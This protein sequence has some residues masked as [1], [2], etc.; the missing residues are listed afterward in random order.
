[1]DSGERGLALRARGAFV[2]RSNTKAERHIGEEDALQTGPLN[3][4]GAIVQ[5]RE[6][7]ERRWEILKR[8]C[9]SEKRTNPKSGRTAMV[10]R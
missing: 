7:V 4:D 9:S 1:M 2:A 3:R 5:I 6:E 8:Y 10:E